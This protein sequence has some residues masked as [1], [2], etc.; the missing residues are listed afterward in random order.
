MATEY[1]NLS[2]AIK[3]KI[4]KKKFGITMNL[5]FF[6]VIMRVQVNLRAV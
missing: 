6:Q 2:I 5:F 1:L 4:Y 3:I